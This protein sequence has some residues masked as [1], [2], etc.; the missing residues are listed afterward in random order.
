MKVGRGLSNTELDRL[1]RLP[2]GLGVAI[3]LL[4]RFGVPTRLL[5]LLG[6]SGGIWMLLLLATVKRLLLFCRGG[7]LDV[8]RRPRA[9][10]IS[11][12]LSLL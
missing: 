7:V 9:F 6:C 12:L 11:L 5:L 8:E 10:G 2:L 1:S 3:A 4:L